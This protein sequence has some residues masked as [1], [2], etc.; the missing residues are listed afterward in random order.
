V[1][2]LASQR[3]QVLLLSMINKAFREI[4]DLYT[5]FDKWSFII[6]TVILLLTLLAA[7]LYLSEDFEKRD[8]I[9]GMRNE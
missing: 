5:E 7:I 1:E 8:H 9:K 3:F 4:A 2:C 6:L